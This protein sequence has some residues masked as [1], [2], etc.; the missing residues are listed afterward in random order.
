MR[1]IGGGRESTNVHDRRGAGGGFGLGRLPLGGGLGRGL[2]MRGGLGSLVVLGLLQWLSGGNLGGL[3]GLHGGGGSVAV[4]AEEQ[5]QERVVKLVLG[6]TE[7]VWGELFRARGKTYREPVLV[8]FRDHVASAC[9]SAS[10]AVGPFYCPGDRQIYLDLGFFTELARRHRAPG[11]FAQAYVVAHEVAHH[12]QNLLGNSDRVRAQQQRARGEAES[13][14]WSV[15]LELQADCLAGVW[16]HHAQRKGLEL[17]P[18]DF[19]EAIRAAEA[20]GDDALQRRA[21]GHVVPDS[22]T[23]GTSAQRIAWFRHGFTTG[24]LD[25]ADTFDETIWERVN[26]R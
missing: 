26:P 24:S 25:Q 7:E 12:V 2:V 5:E 13:N 14:R 19:E 18:G 16:A 15:R 3:L 4:T 22:F 21:R 9:G 10:S 8:L 11:D 23:H 1:W 17:E 6:S 20:I